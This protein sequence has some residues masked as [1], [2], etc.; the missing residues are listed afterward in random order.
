MPHFCSFHAQRSDE[1]LAHQIHRNVMLTALGG[2]ELLSN[3]CITMLCMGSECRVDIDLAGQLE[4]A[5]NCASPMRKLVLLGK[6]HRLATSFDGDELPCQRES[7]RA[8]WVAMGHM[9]ALRPSSRLGFPT[10]SPRPPMLV[11]FVRAW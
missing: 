9:V 2:T 8:S 10:F 7:R 5:S 11:R 4:S 3:R 1:C 6:V